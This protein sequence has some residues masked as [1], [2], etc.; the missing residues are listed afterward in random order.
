M[1]F[2]NTDSAVELHFIQLNLVFS[3]LFS[4]WTAQSL[5]HFNSTCAPGMTRNYVDGSPAA[6]FLQ[7][8]RLTMQ[9]FL[10]QLPSL[11]NYPELLQSSFFESRVAILPGQICATSPGSLFAHYSKFKRW[12]LL[13]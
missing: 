13:N 5:L 7:S 10:R 9:F 12:L 4:N 8:R 3:G 11:P 2:L 1:S 6:R